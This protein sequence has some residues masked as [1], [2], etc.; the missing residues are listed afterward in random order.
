[1]VHLVSDI[2]PYH[3]ENTVVFVWG[4]FTITTVIVKV[5]VGG[6]TSTGLA[7]PN[8]ALRTINTIISVDGERMEAL[9]IIL[10]LP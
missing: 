4:I 5:F 8:S 2:S 10:V 6:M 1:M 9:A 3:S 7:D